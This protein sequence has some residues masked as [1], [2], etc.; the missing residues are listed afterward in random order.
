MNE[1]KD[2]AN[3]DKFSDDPEED[4]RMQNDFLK[5]KMMT[6]RGGVFGGDAELPPEIENEFLKNVMAFEKANDQAKPTKVYDLLGKPD[7]ESEDKLDDE[8]LQTEFSRLNRLL[9]DH[10]IDVGFQRERDDRFK[11]QFIT[12]ELFQHE[13]PFVPVKGMITGFIYE[14]FHPDHE[15]EITELTNRFLTDFLERNLDE[16][17]FYIGEEI[18]EPNGNVVP[19]DKYMKQF[20]TM[21][22]AVPKF[23]NTSYEI[24]NQDYELQETEGELA[25]MG[26]GEGTI[27][28]DL[29]FRDGERKEIHGPFKI[30]FS[31]HHDFWSICFFYLAGFNM[32]PSK[33]E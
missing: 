20:D 12:E 30:Y 9:E 22:E 7:F 23:E 24:E 33:K 10:G 5:L 6:E 25:G 15:L 4:L 19:R 32:H 26:F 28:Y 16:D 18:I 29:I 11:Y 17:T 1:E 31:R 2:Q 13:T 14:E 21:Y 3:E 27:H 8:A